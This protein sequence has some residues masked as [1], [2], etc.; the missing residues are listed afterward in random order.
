MPVED[1]S[2]MH[3]ADD[4]LN[5]QDFV[6]ADL[7]RER[8]TRRQKLANFFGGVAGY[9]KS[10]QPRHNVGYLEGLKGLIA[11]EAFLWVFFRTIVPGAIFESLDENNAPPRYQS[12]LREVF[13]PLFWDGNLQASFFVILSARI[14]CIRFLE[15]RTAESMAGTLFRRGLRLW[16][17]VAV[18]L[19]MCN[20]VNH[21]GGFEAIRY[22]ADIFRNHL[23]ET[24]YQLPTVL[25]YFNA[26][27]NLF[28]YIDGTQAGVRAFPTGQLWIVPIV[29][30]ESFTVYTLMI[31][32]P[33][34]TRGWRFWGL[35]C[36]IVIS[37]WL[38]SW[39]W[40]GATG[41]LFGELVLDL[42]FMEVSKQGMGLPKTR[43]RLSFYW[44]AALFLSIGIVLKYVYEVAAPNHINDELIVHSPIYGG[45]L[46]RDFDINQ[47]QQRVSS[48][49]V[50]VG[51]LMFIEMNVMAQKVFDNP[52][53]RYFGRISFGWFLTQSL[54]IYT[55]GIQL[56]LRLQYV[57]GWAPVTS[58]LAV[59]SAMFVL[60]VVCADLFTRL[61]DNPSKWLADW[62]FD[63]IRR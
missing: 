42:N 62:L 60:T 23:V 61:V 39:A 6:G 38:N 44:V 48:W 59:F 21:A 12:V 32:L 41:L 2:L 27:F 53:F 52:V 26:V 40:Y 56:D 3:N 46:N 54:I 16:F 25:S 29:Y 37:W 55:V 63:W 7:D 28:W 8:L 13:S 20:A 58:A 36:F 35:V 5:E 43:K 11:I 17:P 19:G 4:Q 9:R 45:G 31:L 30:Q 15:N 50:V 33:Y 51:A 34:M 14:V 57:D 24:P 49:F 10:S 22:H 18:S 1:A 47:P